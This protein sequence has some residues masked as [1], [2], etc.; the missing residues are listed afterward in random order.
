MI[1]AVRDLPAGFDPVG[2]RVVSVS[3][4]GFEAGIPADVVWL[5]TWNGLEVNHLATG[6]GATAKLLSFGGSLEDITSI[7][8]GDVAR[9]AQAQVAQRAVVN[10]PGFQTP[11]EIGAQ[12]RQT[13]EE[14]AYN[15]FVAGQAQQQPSALLQFFETQ[16]HLQGRGLEG[17]RD[18]AQQAL[19]YMD[20]LLPVTQ[21]LTEAQNEAAA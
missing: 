10:L 14:R 5:E 19:E 13:V 7:A 1:A 3:G 11:G 6:G 8:R 4:G 15:L 18:A 12:A 2:H 21:Q 16:T 9:Q 20:R 17:V